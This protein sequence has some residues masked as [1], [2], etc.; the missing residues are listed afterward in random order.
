VCRYQRE[1]PG[2][3]DPRRRKEDQRHPLRRRL[4][5]PRTRPRPPQPI[6]HARLPLHPLRHR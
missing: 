1:R 4:A 3:F 6:R 5:P 2:E